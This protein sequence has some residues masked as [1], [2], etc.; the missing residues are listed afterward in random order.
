MQPANPLR[1]AIDR[2]SEA[3]TAALRERFSAATTADFIETIPG[4]LVGE[5][6]DLPPPR[7][8]LDQ[9]R[10]DAPLSPEGRLLAALVRRVDVLTAEVHGLRASL[11]GVA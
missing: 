2:T 11:P 5:T 9:F 10:L 1:A 4:L 6:A 8:M 7:V 3:D